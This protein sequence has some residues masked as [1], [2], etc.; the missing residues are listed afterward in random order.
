MIFNIVRVF[1]ADDHPISFELSLDQLLYSGNSIIVV[2]FFPFSFFSFF[3]VTGFRFISLCPLSFPTFPRSCPVYSFS[4]RKNVAEGKKLGHRL[5]NW[6]SSSF[7]I[8]LE[9]VRN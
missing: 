3:F 4:M 9:E 5:R 8:L 2:S 7:K 6:F 1:F